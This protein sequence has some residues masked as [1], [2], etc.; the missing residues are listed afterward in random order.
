MKKQIIPGKTLLILDEIQDCLRA[1]T[2]LKYFCENLPELHVA[3]AGSLLG[4]ALKQDY[5]AEADSLK[6]SKG[7]I[8]ENYAMNEI[9]SL[10]KT[11]YYWKSGNT[12]EITPW[13]IIMLSNRFSYFKV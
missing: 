9:I 10:K 6:T 1:I 12:A 2:S 11:P 5:T 13:L 8:T 3:C 7:A 4:V